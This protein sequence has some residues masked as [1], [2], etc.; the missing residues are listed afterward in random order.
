LGLINTFQNVAQTAIQNSNTQNRS[1]QNQNQSSNPNNNNNQ[2]Q[3]ILDFLNQAIPSL[4]NSWPQIVSFT[5]QIA[6]VFMQNLVNSGQS[7]RRAT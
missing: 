2:S 7:F 3:L 4:S 6:N 1:N 5:S